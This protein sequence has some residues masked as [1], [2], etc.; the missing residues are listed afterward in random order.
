MKTKENVDDCEMETLTVEMRRHR[1]QLL[2]AWLMH[3]INSVHYYMM[4]CVL[5]SAHIRLDNALTQTCHLGEMIAF[6]DRFIDSVHSQ[7]LQQPSGAYIR[8]AINEVIPVF[9]IEFVEKV[10]FSVK[11]WV[12]VIKV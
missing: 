7:C 12:C 10:N 9:L 2:R 1:L 3:F 5:E 4:E 6:H 11:I 8:D